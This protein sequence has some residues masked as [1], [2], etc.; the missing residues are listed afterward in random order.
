MSRRSPKKQPRNKNTASLQVTKESFYQGPLPLPQ[1]LQGYA[2][3]DPTIPTMIMDNF[4][5]ESEH[6]RNVD[7]KIIRN[8]MIMFNVGNLFALIAVGLICYVG[9]TFM[10]NGYPNQGSGIIGTVVI[11]M[12]AVFLKGKWKSKNE[13]VG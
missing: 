5:K 9:Y 12:A 7:N 3:I 8:G 10:M 2:E 4:N 6:R 11:G 13:E 1:M